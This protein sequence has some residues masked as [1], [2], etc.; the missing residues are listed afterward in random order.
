MNTMTHHTATHFIGQ[1]FCSTLKFNE[2]C[3]SNSQTERLHLTKKIH[4][5]HNDERGITTYSFITIFILMRHQIL[6]VTESEK[7]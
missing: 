3:T 7:L 2:C 1:L 4:V 6:S 5:R